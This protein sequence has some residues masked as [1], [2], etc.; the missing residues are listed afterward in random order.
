MGHR[1]RDRWYRAAL[2]ARFP[3]LPW[4]T[5]PHE[6]T[7]GGVAAMR[8]VCAACPVRVECEAAVRDEAVTAG[9]WAGAY[10]NRL[11]HPQPRPGQRERAPAGSRVSGGAA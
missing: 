10:R 5:E 11:P 2:C 9:F 8:T 6:A 7:R 4:V 3:N 1:I